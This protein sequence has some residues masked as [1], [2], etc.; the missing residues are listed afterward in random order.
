MIEINN[1]SKSYGINKIFENES[2]TLTN[3]CI[4]ALVGVN[5]IGK[6]TFLNSI[7]QPSTLDKGSVKIDDIPSTDFTAKYH[8]AFVPDTKDMFLN[9]TGKEYLQFVSELY[10]QKEKFDELLAIYIP[11][12]KLENSLEQTISSYSLGMKQK[13]YLAGA[14]MSNAQNIILDEPFNAIDP[15]S[16][17]IIKKILFD[18]K[19]TGKMILFSV[20]NLDLVSNFC[21]KIIFIDNGKIILDKTRDD[22]LESFGI[23]KCDIDKFDTIDKADYICYKKNKY[24]YEFLINDKEKLSKKYNDCVIDKITLEDTNNV[25]YKFNIKPT[26]N[27][28]VI[29]KDNKLEI[30]ALE[31][32]KEKLILEKQEVSNDFYLLKSN[33]VQDVI[34]RGNINNYKTSYVNVNI[35]DGELILKKIDK[36]EKTFNDKL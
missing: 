18:L 3:S 10:N 23:L 11:K 6:S 14:F 2:I 33:N 22:I 17:S 36:D 7:I 25:L 32:T 19:D 35:Y 24:D 15:E 9:L 30:T 13:I 5:G 28:K 21:D 34:T 26:N 4:Y 1:L 29:K 27:I 31:K 12:L 8:Y 16:T 20:H